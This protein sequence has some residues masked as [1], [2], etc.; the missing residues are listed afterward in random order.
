MMVPAVFAAAVL[1]LICLALATYRLGTHEGGPR[2]AFA[3][4]CVYVSGV[5]AS[6]S[7]QWPVLGPLYPFFGTAFAG[8][9]FLGAARFADIQLPRW[10][11]PSLVAIAIARAI[12]QPYLSYVVVQTQGFVL[13]L[14]ATI[15]ASWAIRRRRGRADATMWEPVLRWSLPLIPVAHAGLAATKAAGA[16][17]S[18]A[19]IA[20]LV[21]GLWVAG[22]QTGALLARGARRAEQGRA[23]L[24]TLV[25]AVP[26][27]L[28]LGDGDGNI[29]ATNPAFAELLGG[30]DAEKLIGRPFSEAGRALRDALDDSSSLDLTTA[31]HQELRLRDGRIVIFEQRSVAGRAGV[32][33][34]MLWLLRDVTEERRLTEALD[35]SRR[36]ETLGRL[37]G[38]VAHDFN[39]KLTVILGG[40]ALLR[41][42]V[43][44]A[45]PRRRERLDDLET[46]AQYCA[47]LTRDLLDFA[48]K[49]PRAPKQIATQQYL[50]TL[51]DRLRRELPHGVAL[52]AS[53]SPDTPDVEAD[54]VHLERVLTN[55]VHNARD[56]LG[57]QG[58]IEI[59]A[60]PAGNDSVAITVRD[61][62]PGMDPA[63]S[64]RAFDPFFTTKGPGGGTGLGLAIVFSLVESNG[65][66]VSV[67]TAPGAG[68]SFRTIWPRFGEV[69]VA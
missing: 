38:G 37:A 31:E 47:D 64:E 53:V 69:A 16:D 23:T 10:V 63:T 46:A 68:A 15:G 18:T 44:K 50:A 28:A 51:A 14:A 29:R 8:L 3:W 60:S 62:G 22:L 25:D 40:A 24:A 55:L 11:V 6:A 21:V 58:H 30:S 67:E 17:E 13:L 9:L 1:F 59:H 7:A 66:E 52:D 61:D 41:P 19:L 36:L 34:G 56:A 43:E 5:A 65:G 2:W 45:E 27:G 32:D 39:N 57:A 48:K 54:S 42:I 4:V 20:W 35:R 33:E 49:S 26:A 12:S